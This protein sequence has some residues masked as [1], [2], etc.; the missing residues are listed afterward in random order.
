MRLR[1]ENKDRVDLP[2]PFLCT[3]NISHLA[4]DVNTGGTHERKPQNH[5]ERAL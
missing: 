5:R 2:P 3:V 1:I 4:P